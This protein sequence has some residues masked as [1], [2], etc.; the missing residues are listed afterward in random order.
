MKHLKFLCVN[1][2]QIPRHLHV[3][4]HGTGLT[5]LRPIILCHL[6][7]ICCGCFP[8]GL[9]RATNSSIRLHDSLLA[10]KQMGLLF[11]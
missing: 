7:K 9:M 6:P 4:L 11:S 1:D 2:I 10:M 8:D 5:V 3:F